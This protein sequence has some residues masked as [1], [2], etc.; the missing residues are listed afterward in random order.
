MEVQIAQKRKSAMAIFEPA[1][2]QYFCAQARRNIRQRAT[3]VSVRGW[4]SGKSWIDISLHPL[5]FLSLSVFDGK[6]HT[7]SEDPVYVFG[8]LQNMS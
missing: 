3:D 8:S 1:A 4:T 6:Y 7:L 2:G 5:W